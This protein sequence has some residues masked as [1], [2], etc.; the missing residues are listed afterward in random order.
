MGTLIAKARKKAMKLNSWSVESKLASRSVTRSKAPSQLPVAV[1][2][3][4][5]VARMA[6]S[7]SREPTSVYRTNFIVA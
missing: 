3:V 6:T 7:M 5:A 1:N 4:N 2:Q